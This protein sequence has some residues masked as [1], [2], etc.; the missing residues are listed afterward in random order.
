M[1]PVKMLVLEVDYFMDNGK[2][3][4]RIW[5]K[6]QAG[7]SVVVL[8]DTFIPYFYIE[9]AKDMKEQ[10]LSELKKKLMSMEVEARKPRRIETEERKFLSV[11]KRLMKIYVGNPRDVPKFRELVKEWK[12]IRE[13]Y[14]YSIP[15]YRRYLIDRGI[16][17]MGWIEVDGTKAKTKLR[18]DIVMKAKSIRHIDYEKLPPLKTLAFDIETVDEDEEPRAIMIS[19]ADSTGFEKVLTYKNLKFRGK[20]VLKDEASLLR[21]FT[22]L[23]RER[24]PDIVVGYNTDRFDFDVISARASKLGVELRL[25]R[26]E[27]NM[28]FVR[29]VGV[30]AARLAGRVHVD[31]YDFV[32]KIMSENLLTDVLTLNNVSEELIGKG[33]KDMS[34]K[35]IR[36][37]WK[38]GDLREVAEYC[39][40]DSKLTLMLSRNI[41]PQVTEMCRVTGQS[42][43]DVS[44][45]TYAQLVEWLLMRKAHEAGEISPNRPKYEEVLKRRKYPP[46]T[47]GYVHTPKEGLHDKIALFDFKSLYPSITITHNISPETLDCTCCRGKSEKERVPGSEHYYCKS[48]RGFIPAIIEELVNSRMEIKKRMRREKPGTLVYR[49]LDNRQNALKILANSSYGYYGYAG[50]RW[51]SRVCAESITSFGRFYIKRVIE[52][53]ERSGFPVIY[54]DTDSLF[55]KVK[56]IRE[57]KEFLEKVNK[58]LPGVMELDFEGFYRS[59]LFVLAKT[60]KA[61]KKRYALIDRNDRIIIR[62]FERVRRDWSN[63]AKETQEKVL[64]AILKDRSP[65]KAVKVVRETLKRI[66]S[67]EVSMENLVIFSQLTRPIDQYEQVGPHVAAAVKA[68]D[69]GRHIKAGSVISYVITKGTGTISQRAEPSED[70]KDYDPEYYIHNQV[71]PAAMRILSG[72][73]FSEEE[74]LSGKKE[75]QQSIGNYIKLGK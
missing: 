29:R 31:L 71:M 55:L 54:G 7:K 11:P 47:G 25:G 74:V 72:L 23:M 20:E 66:R 36:D 59:G 63:I 9:P 17:P 37:L 18:A 3:V 39:L 19:M 35:R 43:F 58:S 28:D 5:G 61:A 46:Y 40:W 45:M 34:W 8:D 53:A 49:S 41:I 48:R 12:E 44:R 75:S 67:G 62:G 65:D 33:K 26:D 21:R 16:R 50:S 51:Y 30:S 10:E 42:M 57:A 2:P 6:T 56:S 22:E 52:K 27:S 73:G 15:F 38:S 24:D 32:S 4:I 1:A 13:E 64:R 14:E 70:A 60:G 68:M 69:R